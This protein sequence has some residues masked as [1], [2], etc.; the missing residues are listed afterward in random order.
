MEIH[1]V[2]WKNFPIQLLPVCLS[3][4]SATAVAAVLEG[5]LPPQ[6]IRIGLWALGIDPDPVVGLDPS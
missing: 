5:P 4:S 6:P 1:R 3:T 2:V